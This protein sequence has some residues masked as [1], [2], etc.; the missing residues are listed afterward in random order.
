MSVR[1]EMSQQQTFEILEVQTREYGRFN[2]RGTEWNVRLNPTIISGTTPPP[3]PVSHF[4]DSVNNLFDHVLEDVGDADRFGIT[5][6]NEVNQSD[7]AVGIS[8]RRKDQLLADVLWNVFD[9]L[10]QF[11]SRFNT[12]DTF[13]VTVHSVTMPV[14]FGRDIIKQKGRPLAIM[15]QLKRSN[16]E[17]GDEENF[18]AH[19]LITAIA[20]L[21]NDPNYTS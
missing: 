13:I 21:N 17:V 6:H 18:S 19:A 12:L 5:I 20:R 7:K 15:V 1:C 11:N 8:F 14:G 10:T 9:K 16:L 2:T 4:V 3:N